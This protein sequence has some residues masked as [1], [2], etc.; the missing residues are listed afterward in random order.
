LSYLINKTV[1]WEGSTR[2]IT[3]TDEPV[4]PPAVRAAAKPERQ[5]LRG[6]RPDPGIS[7][8]YN[9]V[10]RQMTDVNGRPV[11]PILYNGTNYA[12]L[13]GALAL[14]GITPQWEPT[15]QTIIFNTEEFATNAQIVQTVYP[16]DDVVIADIIITPAKYAVDP[17]GRAD[18]TAG[19]QK[20]LDDCYYAGGGTVFL[21]AGKYLVTQSNIMP[22]F[23]NLRGDWNDPDKSV[24]MLDYGT[25]I[26]ADVESTRE[27]LPAL[28]NLRGTGGVKGLTIFYP[29]QDINNVKPF[30]Y[31][32][33]MPGH[34]IG[35]GGFMLTSIVDV[36]VINGYKGIAASICKREFG[37]HEQ[38][39][40]D[41]VKGTFLYR[42]AELY[43]Q[44]DVG[45]LTNV[46]FDNKYWANAPAEFNPPSR[47]RIDAFTR[48][49]G[50]GMILGDLEW[51]QFSNISISDYKTGIQSVAGI[52]W[53]FIGSFYDLY[54]RRCGVALQVDDI[55]MNWGGMV[56][57]RG[58]LEGED[59]AIRNNT[60]GLINLVGVEVRG[61]VS[62]ART[63]RRDNTVLGA[64][65]KV[66]YDRT[67]L[68]PPPVL[69]NVSVYGADN[70]GKSDASSRIQRALNDAEES[71]GG[72]VYLP[73]GYYRLDNPL[74]VGKNVLLRGSAAL[75]SRDQMHCRLDSMGTLILA[76]YRETSNPDNAQALITLSGE[77]A[78]ISGMR[79]VY[80]L[81]GVSGAQVKRY[82]YTIRGTARGVYAANLTF[83]NA[84]NGIDFRNCDD[85]IIKYVTGCYF[86][87]G[88]WVG[89]KNGAIEGC[90]TNVTAYIRHELGRVFSEFNSW[91]GVDEVVPVLLDSIT[92]Q[93]THMI[94]I[95]GAENQLVLNSFAY[96][97][98]TFA[99]VTNSINTRMVN[100]GLDNGGDA[101]VDVTGGD[102]VIV[103]MMRYNGTSYSRRNT[104]LTIYN[105]TS[106]REGI[107]ASVFPAPRPS[108]LTELS[109]VGLLGNH[110][111]LYGTFTEANGVFT[112]QTTSSA[113][114]SIVLALGIPAANLSALTDSNKF[115]YL[116]FDIQI[117]N[118]RAI[119]DLNVE[120][121]SSGECD[122]D[123]YQWVIPKEMLSAGRNTVRLSFY[124]GLNPFITGAPNLNRINFIRWFMVDC[125]TGLE[126]R[127]EG[128]RLAEYNEIV[129]RLI[130]SR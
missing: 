1:S 95:T 48:Q 73:A 111:Y 21:P 33:H 130:V 64:D 110:T 112:S 13:R 82:S 54:V 108:T 114:N 102:C 94:K 41:N 78:G 37:S 19:I 85:H 99:S 68:R 17:T 14:F 32:F 96:G 121:T 49:N 116:E 87:N 125:G 53:Y 47:A 5:I 98:R 61:P 124:D 10:V 6:V 2:T 83:I 93:R 34:D 9:G 25:V 12:P 39:I 75:P 22:A 3:I 81:N 36:T 106:I 28:F 91:L 92:R 30:P 123:E 128:M 113:D 44:S 29:K 58:V 51:T 8:V 105:R 122:V 20:A 74:T 26:L 89:G 101:M 57:A 62:G 11:Y 97:V 84:Y 16:T 90:L 126:L 52:R 15:T 80:P 50:I 127:I 27:D 115:T 40:A 55:D 71:G 4:T 107:E 67:P 31:T 38:L 129:D 77:N 120:I 23:V 72:I 45:I 76:Y 43:N 88:F 103:N 79:F 35:Y 63:V 70:T 7:I 118:I 86:N 65:F 56:L 104:R 66:D 46:T 69:F 18:S 109:S 117:N 100:I 42:G 59:Y 24:S 60:R 119:N